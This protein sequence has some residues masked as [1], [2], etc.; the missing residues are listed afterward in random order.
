[1]VVTGVRVDDSTD[2]KE[3][4]KDGDENDGE[5]RFHVINDTLG[6]GQVTF[7]IFGMG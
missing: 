7:S 4:R 1:M 3:N 2:Q 6:P 5:Q